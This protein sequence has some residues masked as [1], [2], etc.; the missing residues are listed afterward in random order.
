MLNFKVRQAVGDTNQRCPKDI[1][2]G[3]FL[4]IK[5]S[6]RELSAP[7]SNFGESSKR[8]SL[9]SFVQAGQQNDAEVYILC[10]EL[11][12]HR[13]ELNVSVR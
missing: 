6:L 5:L 4:P 13:L 7:L 3:L 9:F 10:L 2:F 12:T 11:I 1:F 8:N